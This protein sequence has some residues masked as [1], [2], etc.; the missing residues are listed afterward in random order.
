MSINLIKDTTLSRPQNDNDSTQSIVSSKYDTR[1]LLISKSIYMIGQIC[2]TCGKLMTECNGHIVTINDPLT[3]D[4]IICK[5]RQITDTYESDIEIRQQFSLIISDISFNLSMI[6]Q[7]F[8]ELAE[9]HPLELKYFMN[10]IGLR[11]INREINVCHFLEYICEKEAYYIL[12]E[13]SWL[14]E[15]IIFS[16]QKITEYT[17]GSKIDV[18]YKIVMYQINNLLIRDYITFFIYSLCKINYIK[19]IDVLTL[20]Y[21]TDE[22]YFA[23]VIVFICSVIDQSKQLDVI[24][25]LHERDIAIPYPLTREIIKNGSIVILKYCA[26]HDINLVSNTNLSND[27]NTIQKLLEQCNIQPVHMWNILHPYS[28]INRQY[29]MNQ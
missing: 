15:N 14:Y 11:T 17:K 8:V 23:R 2:G 25:F 3:L 4:D 19:I 20:L 13:H 28:E 21:D 6:Q 22:T 29:V 9:N 12:D 27:D 24:I 10:I 18:F 16:D 5:F 1:G 7:I 26:Q